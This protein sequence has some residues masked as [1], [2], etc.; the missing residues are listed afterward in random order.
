MRRLDMIR[1]SDSIRRAIAAL[2]LTLAS[3]APVAA[4]TQEGG[5]PGDWLARYTSART[6]GMG[7][8]FVA[9]ADDALGAMWNPAGLA[10]MDQNAL[11]FE[12]A[13]LFE[14]TSINTLSF[15]VPGSRWPGFAAT[16]V[17]LNSGEFERTNE[18]NDPL[19]TFSQGEMAFL[20]TLSKNI[21]PKLAV[22]TN[23]KI[24]RQEVEAFSGGGVGFDVGAMFQATPSLRIGVSALNVSGPSVRLRDVDETYPMEF[25]GG[26]A[27][28]VLGG[29]GI[30]AAEVDMPG[31]GQ[32]ARLRGGAEYAIVP[33]FLLRAGYDTDAAT[34]GL[35]YR[36]APQYQVDY[37]LADHTLGMTH[38]VGVS[39]RFGGFF[40][41]SKADPEIFSPTGERAVTKI[42]LNARTKAEAGQW[43]LDI[44]SKSDEVIRRFG[45]PGMPPPH[46]LWDG[47][48]ETGLPVADGIYRY[49]LE[50]T[51]VAGRIVASATRTVEISTGGPQGTVP[52]YGAN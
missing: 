18:L 41:S 20:F 13:R 30:V 27:A 14:E 51:D 24:V 31:E 12:N 23:V 35:S 47:K 38:R 9:V 15:A 32:S 29:K 34:G 10:F 49:H 7:G 26:L 28:H 17:S 45:G 39:Y 22:G 3:A 36:F 8:A 50:V 33:G 16:A 2:A 4:Q 52:V 48:D 21:N 44:V 1:T 40:A 46:V 37:A 19:G 43:R 11:A 42:Q 25:R 5:V 6:L